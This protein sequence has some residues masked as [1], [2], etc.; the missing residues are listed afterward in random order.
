[1]ADK[2]K[3]GSMGFCVKTIKEYLGASDTDPDLK[4]KKRKAEK[5][6]DY[7]ET[8]LGVAPDEVEILGCSAN[9]WIQ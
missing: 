4:E 5:A 3:I 9:L 8:L 1:M 6:A 7:L 2:V